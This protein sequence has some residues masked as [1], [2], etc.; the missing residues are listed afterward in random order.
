MYND[1]FIN[2]TTVYLH[3]YYV[4]GKKK[5]LMIVLQYYNTYH[6]FSEF[7]E[8]KKNYFL[9]IKKKEINKHNQCYTLCFRIVGIPN[10]TNQ[11]EKNNNFHCNGNGLTNQDEPI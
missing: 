10:Q 9:V 6:F 4:F 3:T 1:W 2:I 7:K 11:K 5:V 8:F